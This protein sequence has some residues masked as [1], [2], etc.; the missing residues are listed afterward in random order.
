MLLLAPFPDPC[1]SID[2]EVEGGG[3]LHGVV[4]HQLDAQ[5]VGLNTNL[6]TPSC[7]QKSQMISLLRIDAKSASRQCLFLYP[8]IGKDAYWVVYVYISIYIIIYLK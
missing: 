1:L 3:D 7:T 5:A 2:S 4:L 6:M 8:T